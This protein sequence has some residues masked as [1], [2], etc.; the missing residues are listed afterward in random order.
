MLEAGAETCHSAGMK[1]K[2]HQTPQSPPPARANINGLGQ[3]LKMF[4]RKIVEGAAVELGISKQARGFSAW[5]HLG[6]MFF[7]QLSHAMSLNDICDWLSMKRQAIAGFG[8]TPPAR[9][10]L[11]HANATRSAQFVERVF[12]EVLDLFSKAEP[13]FTRGCA[14]RRRGGSGYLRRFRMK[15]FAVDSTVLELVANCMSWAAHRRRKAAA[16]MHLR[17]DLRSC[18][19]GYVVV[20]VGREHDSRRAR[21]LCAG[22]QREEI[23]VFDRAY[24]NFAHLRDLD[25]RGVYWVTRAKSNLTYRVRKK[26]S[27]PANSSIIKDE[28]I[29]LTGPKMPH[30]WA[31]RRVEA[32]VEI[33]GELRRMV[34]LTNHQLWSARSVCELYRARWGIEVFFKQV[35]QTLKL[36]SFLGYNLNAIRWQV[37]VALLVYVLLRFAAYRSAWVHSFARLFAVIRSAIFERLD[38]IALLRRYGTAPPRF[39]IRAAFQQT[40]LPGFA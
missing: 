20:D 13:D 38:L 10:T 33:E 19:P 12:W 9:N 5:S 2:K 32:W 1:K 31:L 3:L 36:S 30:D 39:K 6:A 35:K 11:S 17:L 26:L 27:V 28:I 8:M 25:T 34:F 16:K 14:Q 21:E 18:L 15:I 37:W 24:G 22:L 7:A 4:P 40:W 23:S 29:Q